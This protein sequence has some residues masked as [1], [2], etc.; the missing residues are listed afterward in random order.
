MSNEL[1][2]EQSYAIVKNL[3]QNGVNIDVAL[4]SVGLSTD[5]LKN[6]DPVLYGMHIGSG[7]M[8]RI[9]VRNMLDKGLSHDLIKDLTG[10]PIADF[11]IIAY[12]YKKRDERDENIPKGKRGRPPRNRLN[13]IENSNNLD[14][15]I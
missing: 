14:N 10:I 4:K 8:Q 7:K 13:T 9:I 6:I 3:I 5:S 1:G 12:Q 11:R 15:E 2:V